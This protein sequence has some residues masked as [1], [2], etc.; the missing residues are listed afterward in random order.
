M[1]PHKLQH[2]AQHLCIPSQVLSDMQCIVQHSRTLQ[3]TLAGHLGGFIGFTQRAQIPR[4]ATECT[5]AT[6]EG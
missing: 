4:R 5:G 1:I 2:I 3:H 6:A